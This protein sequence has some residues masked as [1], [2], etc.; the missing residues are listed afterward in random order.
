GRARWQGRVTAVRWGPAV[1][2]TLPGE[3]FCQAGLELR[4]HI[5]GAAAVFVLGYT[6]GCPGYLPTAAE[7]PLGG[8][9]VC[10]A[11][12][13]YGM[14]GPFV[15]GALVR[16]VEEAR[17]LSA[18]VGADD[19]ALARPPRG[20]CP[21]PG[22]RR[23]RASAPRAARVGGPARSG[24]PPPRARPGCRWGRRPRSPRTH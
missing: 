5:Q 1:L 14:P 4:A 24:S 17:R 15:P 11:H 21:R 23:P 7:Y 18:V 9:E 6:D 10:D 8:Y 13:Y 12:R 16:V 2:L 3:P 22:T 19:A 20:Q